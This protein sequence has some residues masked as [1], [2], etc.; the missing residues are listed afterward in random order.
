VKIRLGPGARVG[1]LSAAPRVS[2]RD[3]AEAAG[4][5]SHVVG[6]I[7]AFEATGAHVEKFIVG[8]QV[9]PAMRRRS[10]RTF[11]QPWTR[12]AADAARVVLGAVQARRA[13]RAL[14]HRVDWVYERAAALQSLGTRFRGIPWVIE[15]SSLIF[16]E[17]K[18]ERG[19]MV[20]DKLA[21][22]RELAAYHACTAIVAV[23]R[24]LR[25][26]L[27]D[28]G[29]PAHKILVLPNGV[30]TDQFDPAKHA[31]APRQFPG[32]TIGFVGSV[33]GWQGLDLLLE[34]TAAL[35][36]VH[37]AIAG[38]GTARAELE[39]LART[40]GIADRVR[41]VG[42]LRGSDVPRFLAGVDVGYSGQRALGI[43]KMYH[44]PL[45]LYEY[46]AMGKLAIASA[47]DDAR[48]VLDEGA[49][50]FLFEPDRRAALEDAIARAYAARSA[51]LSL[52]A[53]VR[54]ET[55]ARHSWHARVATMMTALSA[56]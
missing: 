18:R 31:S 48:A 32:F 4:P 51:L 14:A 5:R 19:A 37:V 10:E 7:R 40:L 1:Y 12:L 52:G 53:A 24:D 46:L 26:L 44:S 28:A 16:D 17:A 43:G 13:Y 41:F 21:K 42:R 38:D 8:D 20:L 47:Y 2:T 22:Q 50:G 11:D 55:V 49:S 36:D 25:D 6:V 30:D 45:K 56:L 3:D 33:I 39:Q 23:S 27:V 15:T 29:V 35:P 54:A 34:A 9:P